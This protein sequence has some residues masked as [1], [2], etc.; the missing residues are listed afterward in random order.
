MTSK[1]ITYKGRVQGV[2]FRYFTLNV[3]IDLKVAGFVKNLSN[4]DVYVE[5]TA[6]I[7]QIELFVQM[8]KNGPPTANVTDVQITDIP[9]KHQGKFVI[10]H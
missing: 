5:I 10:K 8:T 1:G 9:T 6:L 3:A 4:G 7:E 2:G